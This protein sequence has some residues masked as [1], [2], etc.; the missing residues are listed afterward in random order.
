MATDGPGNLCTKA[1]WY[2]FLVPEVAV[3][4]TRNKMSHDQRRRIWDKGFTTTG[5][6]TIK[7]SFLY[8]IF[9]ALK[10]YHQ[11][12]IEYV[13]RLEIQIATLSAKEQTVNISD[14]FYWLSF[15]IMGEFAFG[16]SF[17]MLEDEEWHVAIRMLR[18]AMRLLG[19]FS[20]VPWLAQIGF[21]L[22]PNTAFIGEWHA[23]LQFCKDRMKE[24]IKVS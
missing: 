19:P 22:F 15:D 1:V 12:T 24:R 4:T 11:R 7:K 8:L 6:F 14:W 10:H 21:A 3:N 18:S 9:P 2:D 16:R 5:M 17:R 23:M 13:G 20:S